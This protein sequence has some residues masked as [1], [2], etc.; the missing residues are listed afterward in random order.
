MSQSTFNLGVISPQDWGLDVVTLD[1]HVELPGLDLTAGEIETRIRGTLDA[2]L[3]TYLDPE[4]G[5]LIGFYRAPDGFREPPQTANLIGSWLFLAAYDR[6]GDAAFLEGARRAL[7][8][9][10]RTFV[11]SHPMAVVAGGARDGVA[12]HQIWTKFSAEFL[13]GALGL[14]RRTEDAA[15]LHRAEQSGRYLIQAARHGFAPLYDLDAHR[16]TDLT[17]GWDA[18]G[19]A[20][21][22]A[23]LL[24]ETTGEARWRELALRW[25]SHGLDVQAENG[26]F[27]LIDA[28]YFNTDLA[29]DELR[30]LC[31]L[32]EITGKPRF[33]AAARRFA[34]WLLAHQRSDGAWA[35][36]LDRD[37]NVVMPTVGPGD[38]PN[39]AIALF[40]LH[41][42]S[43]DGRYLN[44]ALAAFRYALSTQ[45]LPSSGEPYADDPSIRWGFWSWDPYYDYTQSPDQAT[46]HIRGL[47]FLLDYL[48]RAE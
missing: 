35:M 41:H 40:R 30:G 6:Y 9:Y 19:R 18:W 21:E 45:V 44:A 27:Y 34:D 8:F 25:G 17:V 20:V 26:C 2:W 10:D 7:G 32:H 43:D 13:I 23:L 4:T 42:L 24:A 22:A 37:G 16:W 38:M 46:H 12:G 29:A 5:A 48:G 1:P 28:E 3:P 31:F 36:T 39:L 14:Y 15:W 11:V 33:L 47:M